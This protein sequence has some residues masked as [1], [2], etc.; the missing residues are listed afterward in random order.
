MSPLTRQQKTPDRCRLP[1]TQLMGS[2]WPFS[3]RLLV[4]WVA[5][6]LVRHGLVSSGD[7]GVAAEVAVRSVLSWVRVYVPAAVG[8]LEHAGL[9]TSEGEQQ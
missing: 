7:A 8:P 9:T 5:R 3:D 2:P 1:T 4:W 6:D